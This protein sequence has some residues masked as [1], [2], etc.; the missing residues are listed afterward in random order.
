M[1]MSKEYIERDTVINT[2]YWNICEN[3]YFLTHIVTE[4]VPMDFILMEKPAPTYIIDTTS[5]ETVTV[6]SAERCRNDV[7]IDWYPL[8][9]N[10]LYKTS[11]WWSFLAPGMLWYFDSHFE[12]L[13]S[14]HRVI[15]V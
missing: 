4:W 7:V 13:T 9:N 12:P 11:G 3:E 10:K 6:S 14:G 5:I 15:S 1:A 2:W 8:L